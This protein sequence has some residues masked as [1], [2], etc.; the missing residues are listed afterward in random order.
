M[1]DLLE[2]S[3]VIDEAVCVRDQEDWTDFQF[4]FSMTMTIQDGLANRK[5]L[6]KTF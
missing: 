1:Q 4:N 5:H 3:E 2:G 6:K